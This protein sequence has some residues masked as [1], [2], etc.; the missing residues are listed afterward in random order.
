M[1]KILSLLAIASMAL[2]VNAQNE[3]EDPYQW[4]DYSDWG[5]LKLVGNQLSDKYGNP[6]RLKGW[7]TFSLHYKGYCGGEGQWKLMKSLSL[8][9]RSSLT[10][11]TPS[12]TFGVLV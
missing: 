4:K 5:K 1:K 11:S 9:R 8:K 7:S 12:T 10:S 2:G 3:E 6:V